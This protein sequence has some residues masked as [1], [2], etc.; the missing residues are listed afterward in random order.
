MFI[1]V[2]FRWWTTFSGSLYL[3]LV[4]VVLGACARNAA[5]SA[6]DGAVS[7]AIVPMDGAVAPFPR[8]FRF[9]YPGDLGYQTW[10]S[11]GDVC[12][13]REY[14]IPDGLRETSAQ[15]LQC[16]SQSLCADGGVYDAGFF[17]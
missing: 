4:L 5:G 10:C 16:R 2:W 8:C 15:L 13:R 6:G 7:D 11:V 9:A 3:P 1:P 17:R 12:C 14:V